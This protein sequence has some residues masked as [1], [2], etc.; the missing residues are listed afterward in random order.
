MR[1]HDIRRAAWT[2]AATLAGFALGA[3]TLRH[4]HGLPDVALLAGV[5]LMLLWAGRRTAGRARRRQ[6]G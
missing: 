5:F 6:H 4:L 2:A 1:R 3:L